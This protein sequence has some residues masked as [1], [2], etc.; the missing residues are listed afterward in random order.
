MLWLLSAELR[1]TDGRVDTAEKYRFR[2]CRHK[3]DTKTSFISFGKLKSGRGTVPSLRQ[4][5]S[6]EILILRAN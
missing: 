4:K 5:G 6:S 2:V 1:A 3:F